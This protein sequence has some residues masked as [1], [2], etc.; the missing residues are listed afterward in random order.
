MHGTRHWLV[1]LAASAFLVGG[2][3]AET[4]EI[5][6][7]VGTRKVQPKPAAD[8]AAAPRAVAGLVETLRSATGSAIDS[9]SRVTTRMLER[10][11]P[12]WELPTV[13]VVVN[14]TIPPSPPSQSS[15]M[16]AGAFQ[17]AGLGGGVGT[18]GL[19]PWV[20]SNAT[21]ELVPVRS[22]PREEPK[23][24]IIVV[25][26]ASPVVPVDAPG[27][28]LSNEVLLATAALFGFA[29]IGTIL[30]A[31]QRSAA[32]ARQPM[33][34]AVA[35]GHVAVGGRDAGPLPQAEKFD[36]GP[37][38]AEQIVQLQVAEKAGEDAMLLNILDQNLSLRAELADHETTH[39]ER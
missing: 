34:L 21:H 4:P 15:I 25:R 38:Y 11:V 23:P 2:L 17:P 16:P 32:R 3:R 30:V 6:V 33:P 12:R 27:I 37:T 13:P 26:E 19:L 20:K 7:Y 24:T 10:A 39:G 22:E 28:R 35:A 36:L 1:A 29:L 18:P 9:A 31:T 14:V 8:P 5:E